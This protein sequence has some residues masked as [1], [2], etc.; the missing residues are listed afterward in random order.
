MST[1]KEVEEKHELIRAMLREDS[2]VSPDKVVDAVKEKFKTG[3]SK[4][5]IARIRAAEFHIKLGP[6]GKLMNLTVQSPSITEADPEKRLLRLVADLQRE[7]RETNIQSL[8][9]T[10][11]KAEAVQVQKVTRTIR[12]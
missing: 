12:G 10:Q 9:L 8:T 1:R 3:V 7:M 11:E 4:V 6:R 2:R 5:D